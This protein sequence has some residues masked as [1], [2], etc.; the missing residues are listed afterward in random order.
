LTA[1]AARAGDDVTA[2][3]HA[4]RPDGGP[5]VRWI[6][7]DLE[8]E[9]ATIEL[10]RRAA[11]EIVLHTAAMSKP[12][13]C[14]RDPERA[15]RVNTRGSG[16]LA[17]ACAGVGAR[18]VAVSTDLVFDGETPPYGEVDVPRPISR[19]GWTKLEAERVVLENAPGAAV[20]RIALLYGRPAL[21]GS[22]FSEW[23]RTSWEAGKTTALFS[24]QYRTMIGGAN[25]A[26]ALLELARSEFRG[27]IHLAGSER[28]SRLEFGRRLGARLGADPALIVPAAMADVPSRAS[29][30]ADVSLEIILARRVLRTP[31]LDCR[32]GLA[33]AYF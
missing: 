24:D 28:I 23:L 2:A 33:A 5:P 20:A 17:R 18:L 9:R 26:A 11:P 1:A 31:L 19:Y 30:P 10:I 21:G 13:D 29:R 22:S 8:D 27:L 14:E 16:I 32:E 25:L 12:D 15:K 7:L 3:F 6:R 4:G